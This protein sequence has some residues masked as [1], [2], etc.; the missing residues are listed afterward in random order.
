[1]DSLSTGP[2]P[3]SPDWLG[4]GAW[5]LLV[6]SVAA[7]AAFSPRI[8]WIGGLTLVVVLVWQ[9]PRAALHAASFAALAIRPSLDRFSERRLG[10][11]PFTLEPTVIFGAL[12]L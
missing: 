6:V 10:L 1:M 11:G 2:G 8:A 5:L 3:R 9:Y 4:V 7:A 12:I